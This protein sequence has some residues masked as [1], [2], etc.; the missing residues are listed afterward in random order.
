MGPAGATPGHHRRRASGPAPRRQEAAIVGLIEYHEENEPDYRHAGIDIFVDTAYQ[1]RGLG[2][3]AIRALAWYLFRERGHHRLILDPGLADERA[4]REYKWIGFRRV[5]V[6]RSC[7][8]GA[9]VPE[10]AL[11]LPCRG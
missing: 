8:R 5:G 6:M 1:G 11:S 9:R 10:S 4:I 3:D 7:E 2:G